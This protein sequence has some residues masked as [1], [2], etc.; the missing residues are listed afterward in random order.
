MSEQART[1]TQEVAPS[2]DSASLISVIERAAL[3]PDVDIE[4]M[5]RL[6]A[7]HER[8]QQ[9]QARKS[10]MAALAQLQNDIP[11]DI[12]QRGKILNKNGGV[13]STYALWEDI[14][15]RIRPILHRHGFAIS[16]R[17]SQ[18]GGG[19][20][21][22]GVL[23]HED[24]HAEETSINLPHDN[25]G[26]KNAVQA[27]G[28]SVSYGKRYTAGELLNLTSRGEDDDGQAGG[29]KPLT[30]EQYLELRNL[31]EEVG[32]E[33]PKFAAYM[34]VQHLEELPANQFN[35]ALAALRAK[36]K[37]QGVK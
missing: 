20:T 13:Q 10:Y 7:M 1:H 12:P 6:F 18:D 15:E 5:E 36:A 34:R 26:S 19:L 30:A 17:T 32:A 16:F 24:G 35:A 23:S 31:M 28:S 33:E 14:N 22:T 9:A 27:I 8:M 3:N 29:V 37:K 21:V 4:K 2:Q 11:D 25:S